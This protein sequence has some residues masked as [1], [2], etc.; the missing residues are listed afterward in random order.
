MEGFYTA[1]EARAKL[2]VTEDKFQYM[3][4]TDQVRKV[5]LPG[6]KYGVYPQSE[7]DEMAAALTG[8]VHQYNED[9]VKK[10]VFRTARPEDAQ[11]MYELGQ[12]IMERSGGYGIAPDKLIPFLSIPNSEIGHVLIR[13]GQLEGYFT[14]VPLYHDT[15]MQRMREEIW[16]SQIKPEEL[17]Y[18]EPG[19]PIDCF[20]WE[21]MADPDK[22]HTAAYLI[23]KMLIFFHNL[24]K[25]GVDIEGMYATASSPEGINLCRRMGMNLMDLPT[26]RPNNMPF[27][28]K[29]KEQKNWLTKNYIQALKSYKLRQKRLLGVK[30]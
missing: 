9:K 19:K 15:L 29:P 21:V 13:E 8:F 26:V 16:T 23:G 7:I 1:K 14:I 24:G 27:E 3:V 11:A 20:I 18:F 6:R 17:A 30:D 22:K 5:I 2:G 25:R 10:H 28:L 12:R 4:R